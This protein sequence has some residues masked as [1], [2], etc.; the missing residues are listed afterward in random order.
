MSPSLSRRVICHCSVHISSISQRMQSS[1]AALLSTCPVQTTRLSQQHNHTP[2]QSSAAALPSTCPARAQ[3]KRLDCLSSHTITHQCSHLLQHCHRHAQCKRLDCR[4]NTIT[5]QCSQAVIC[6][7]IAIDMPSANDST[8]ATTQSHTNAVICCS[9][10]I[11]M[12]SPG[13][14]QSTRLSQQ[15]NHTPMQS[16]AAA[17]TQ[18]HTDAV[19]CCSI[20]I[21]MPSYNIIIYI[22]RAQ[23]KRLDCRNNTITHRCSHLLQHCYRHAQ[24][25]RNANDSTVAT[26]SHARTHRAAQAHAVICCCSSIAIDNDQK[27][28]III[29][30]ISIIIIV[31]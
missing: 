26:Q 22:A 24:P 13:A 10:A 25:G 29:T 30:I 16:S 21:D 9:I 2:M 11:E 8:V 4:N 12:P 3:C 1:A 5:H 28:Y 18:S 27:D 7:S 6:C 31:V 15:H 14:M 23:C 19:I 20:A 17:T